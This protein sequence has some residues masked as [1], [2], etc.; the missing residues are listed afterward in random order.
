VKALGA[1][2]RGWWFAKTLAVSALF[3]VLVQLATILGVIK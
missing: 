1:A 3:I 2:R